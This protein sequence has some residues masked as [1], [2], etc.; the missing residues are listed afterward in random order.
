MYSE[1]NSDKNFKDAD[2]FYRSLDKK[3]Y[4]E[5][6]NAKLNIRE[7][8]SFEHVNDILARV[9]QY[10]E[11]RISRDGAHPKRQ[12]YVFLSVSQ[13]GKRKMVVIDARR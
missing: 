7:K 12:V 3:E 6:K 4:V 10:G 2:S 11:V 5:F 9:D 1:D 13:D 8:T